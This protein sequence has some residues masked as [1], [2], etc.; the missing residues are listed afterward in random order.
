MR[1]IFTKISAAVL[2]LLLFIIPIS[3]A[4]AAETDGIVYTVSGGRAVITDYKGTAA[5][6][7]IPGTLGG[8]PVREIAPAAF[9][10]CN[11][12]IRVAIP[13]SVQKIG[14]YAFY[15]CDNLQGV[16]I[17]PTVTEIQT[18]TFER[19]YALKEAALPQTI[20]RIGWSAFENCTA[21]TKVTI[22]NTVKTIGYRAFE[23]SGKVVLNCYKG[24]PADQ[25]AA[26]NK[27][28]V[29]YIAASTSMTMK[30][31][32]AIMY[33]GAVLQLSAV[34]APS[35]A[36]KNMAWYS[37]DTS[38][39][40]GDAT[41]RMTAHKIGKA[42]ITVRN[43]DGRT[44]SCVIT[45]TTKQAAVKDAAV[46]SIAKP[47]NGLAKV[48]APTKAAFSSASVNIGVGQ[49]WQSTV[50]LTPEKAESKLTYTTANKA[51]ATVDSAGKIK[52]IKVG[53][54]KITAKTANGKSAVITVNVRAAPSSVKFTKTAVT[55]QKGKTA[56]TEVTF[57]AGK[58]GTV[59]TY[60]SNN[61]AVVT[62]TKQGVLTAKDC[63]EAVITVKTYNGKTAS[64]KVTVPWNFAKPITVKNAA[65]L[66]A[67]NDNGWRGQH[68]IAAA[69]NTPVYSI[70]D[71]TIS[72]YQYYKLID[73]KNQ[74]TSYGNTAVFRSADG[75]VETIMAHL[76][77]FAKATGAPVAVTKAVPGVS[78]TNVF[79][80]G[81]A[82]V[83]RGE[84]IGYVGSSG[85]AYG[86][87]LH[88]EITI[89]GVRMAP[90]GLLG[91]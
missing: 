52:G 1:H 47:L 60:S 91:Y 39:V 14:A 82:T 5:Y 64:I 69:V 2:A 17:P 26:A 23:L 36:Y 58:V 77:K 66:A 63:G 40:S 78:N 37:S 80:C 21:L 16:D 42:T 11:T 24:G 71:G 59:R 19:C 50:K 22:P 32:A 4:G 55:L 79:F 9:E 86:P 74:L 49:T 83:K 67:T 27:L 46:S 85:N 56:A 28:K 70:A 38:V 41:G 34:V 7:T 13:Y 54:V 53:S 44:A 18:S 43:Y 8:T 68:D 3:F 10:D 15:S 57:N 48:A 31:A 87:H 6:L 88:I 45:V 81:T 62:V 33:V 89:D 51:V 25:Y 12:L 29:A 72:Y 30:P 84:L 35:N 20:T 76:N 90:S 61:T 75:R 65:F 73:G